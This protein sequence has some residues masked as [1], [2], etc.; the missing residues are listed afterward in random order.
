MDAFVF[1]FAVISGNVFRFFADGAFMASPAFCI[2]D[3]RDFQH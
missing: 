3:S 2:Y 1:L